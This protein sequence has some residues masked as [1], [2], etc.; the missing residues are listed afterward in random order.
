[1]RKFVALIVAVAALMAITVPA[2][3]K[4][5]HVAQN[6]PEYWEAL[7][8]GFDCFKVDHGFGSSYVADEDYS[9]VVLKGGPASEEEL[10]VEAGDELFAPDNP[11]TGDPYD[12]S[13]IIFCEG[14]PLIS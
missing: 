5:V 13:H 9:L 3:A 14:D 6:Q 11:R 1:M 7:Y 4:P 12:I 2:I 8:E 10:G